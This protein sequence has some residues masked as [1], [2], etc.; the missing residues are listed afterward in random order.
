MSAISVLDVQLRAPSR[1]VVKPR[2]RPAPIVLPAPRV[3]VKTRVRTNVLPIVASRV[4][5]FA[6]IVGFAYGAS[7]MAGQVALERARQDGI[8]AVARA[9][10][11][12]KAE[13]SL[14]SR[15]SVLQNSDQIDS[16]ANTHGFKG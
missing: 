10:A 4:L 8:S 12:V 16:W 11:A 15:L 6:M 9:R 13:T 2:L 14:Q 5:S 3:R 1:E 7:T